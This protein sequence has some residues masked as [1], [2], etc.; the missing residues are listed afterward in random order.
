MTTSVSTLDGLKRDQP[1]WGPWLA[2]VQE[3]LR[4]AETVRWDA[5]IPSNLVSAGTATPLLA[6]AALSVPGRAVRR[7]FKELIRVASID[8]TP[9]MKTL[10]ATLTR[11]LDV[12]ALFTASL[13]QESHRLT[14]IADAC[15]ADG[16]ALQAI[17]GVLPVPFLLSCHRRWVSS[18]PT[19]WVEGYCPLCGSWPAFAEVRGIERSR[20]LRCG[21]CGAEWYARALVCPYCAMSDHSGLVS[22]VPENNDAHAVIDACTRC[23]GYVKTLTRLQG[24]PPH[25]VMLED[26][27]SAAL[28]IAAIGQGFTRPPGAGYHL[29]V[30]V[31]DHDARR[32]RFFAWNT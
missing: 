28:D 31:S 1:D 2:V 3:V 22:F 10:R 17:A 7:L 18:I 19:S 29:G 21:R 30:T 26:L 14:D 12:L 32:R 27:S 20:H 4:E 16:D 23:H 9:A 11:D 25:T 6:H 5:A 15:G 8:G 13:C 24:C